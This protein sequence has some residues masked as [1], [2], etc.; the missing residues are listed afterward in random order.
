MENFFYI[1]F[2]TLVLATYSVLPKWNIVTSAIDLLN[3]EN[4]YTHTYTIDHRNSWYE[5]SDDLKK[6]IKK[7][8]EEKSLIQTQSHWKIKIEIM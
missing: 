7:D 8:N 2:I 4:S 6:T 1:L 5:S 3:A